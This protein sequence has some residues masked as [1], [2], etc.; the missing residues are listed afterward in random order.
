MPLPYFA[1]GKGRHRL[2]KR[3]RSS[4]SGLLNP[5]FACL[6]NHSPKRLRPV[7]PS[8]SGSGLS[9]PDRRATTSGASQGT[10]SLATASTWPVSIRQ[11]PR[12]EPIARILMHYVMSCGFSLIA[13]APETSGAV[14][15]ML[16]APTTAQYGI[17]RGRPN[18]TPKGRC[19]G[20]AR[21]GFT[22]RGTSGRTLLKD[23]D[24]IDTHD[25]SQ[26]GKRSGRRDGAHGIP[27][28]FVGT[29]A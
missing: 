4:R 28:R 5:D 6:R 13:P 10:F 3:F 1:P 26:S 2:P 23:G 22:N 29:C 17:G 15:F 24:R 16:T 8:S 14:R 18:E 19:Q 11:S 20:T 27:Y 7:L 9:V 25:T 21:D 12:C